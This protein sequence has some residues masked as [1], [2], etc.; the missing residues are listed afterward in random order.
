MSLSSVFIIILALY[1]LPLI[2]FVLTVWRKLFFISLTKIPASSDL[3]KRNIIGSSNPKE[4]KSNNLKF[5]RGL[6]RVATVEYILAPFR[7]YLI[8]LPVAF[9]F[10]VYSGLII[11]NYT[12]MSWSLFGSFIGVIVL[13]LWTQF[14][15]A[16]TNLKAAEFIRIY[17]QM[18]PDDFIL[19]YRLD[20]AWGGM[21]ILDKRGMTP[22]NPESLDFTTDKRPIQSYFICAKILIDTMYFAHLCL[23]A[24]RKLGEQYVFEVFDGA[25]SF[26]GKRILQLAKGHLKVMGLDKLNNLKGSFIYIFN[27]KSVFDFVLAFL[28]L[29]TIKVNNRHVRIRFILAKDHF[30]D[31]PL[32]YK[33]FGIGK[34][35]EAV[36]MIFIARKNPKQSNLDLKKAAKFIYEKDIDVAIFPQG[37]RAK[38]K[39][40]RSMKRR[41]AGYYTTIRK[42]DKNSPLSH[43]RK[44][45]SHLIWDTLN[46]LY[47][48]GVNENLNIVFIGINGTGN[49]L[50]KSNLKIQTNT[51]IEFSI[52]EII[53]LNPGIL[54]EL[55]APQEEAQNDPKRDF[56]DQT[57]LMI[58]EN[59]VEAMSLHPMLLQRYLTELKGQFRFENDKIAAIH[60]TIQE[61]SPQSNV[62]FQL[63]DHI[64]SLPSNHW[65]GYLSQLSQLL[66]EKPS[67]ER[68]LNLLED[69]TSELLHLEA[70]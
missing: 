69:V 63:L 37:T 45:S 34:I 29:S 40:N 2:K 23:F 13:M 20:L 49:T 44:G 10:L 35:C 36:N 61:I 48:R 5:W 31:N 52:G 1:L 7:H 59:L 22:I 62:V 43:I 27:H 66:L 4:S 55:F 67:E 12:V 28:A 65:N 6:F 11:F 32:V 26:W 50:P 19:R 70:K 3:F 41:D 21:A 9:A 47:Q 60:D 39:F 58:N 42:K 53:Q 56:L 46:D 17:P 14:S 54:N 8:G 57:N 18:H 64:Y 30:K 51:D 25:A 68:Y 16:Q 38:G 24:Y 33:I 15:R